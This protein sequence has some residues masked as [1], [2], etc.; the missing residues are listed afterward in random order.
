MVNATTLYRT[1]VKGLVYP[2]P[3]SAPISGLCSAS[4]DG[5]N[6]QKRFNPLGDF[7]RQGGVRRLVREILG[8]AEESYEGPPL[9]GG[10]VADCAPESRKRTLQSI[11]NRALSHR[12]LHFERDFVLNLRQLPQVSRK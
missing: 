11:Q 9:L 7:I 12:P 1:R 6:D 10:V 2:R 5:P 3:R 8:A 4:G